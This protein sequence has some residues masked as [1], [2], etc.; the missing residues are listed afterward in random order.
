M[1]E[2]IFTRPLELH[3]DNKPITFNT[4]DEFEFTINSRTAIPLEKIHAAI[5]ASPNEL[6]LELNSIT[7]AIE[8]IT[9]LI[10]DSNE[11]GEVTQQLKE[12]NPV[13]FSN[14]NNWR[15]IFFSLKKDQSAESSHYKKIAL[16]GYLTYLTNRQNMLQALK[17]RF[18]S[19]SSQ[20]QNEEAL[21]FR[22]GE[23]EVADKLDCKS[24]GQQLGMTRITKDE[25]VQISIEKNDK[26]SLLL[27]NYKCKLIVKDAITF[28]D[29][30]NEKYTLSAGENKIGR[31]SDCDI[32]FVD[33]MQR[34]SR[35]HLTIKLIDDKT[36]ELTDHSSY[37]S[38]Y[39]KSKAW[40]AKRSS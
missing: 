29:N 39:S 12:I 14:D 33:T 2:K 16:D 40:R 32:R 38:H 1:L 15:D 4:V 28:V 8:K 22:T 7:V 5:C 6:D 3:I 10:N 23:L 9:E 36:L 37:G 34:I 26:I 24:L 21:S 30:N 20:Q 11:S 31:G 25:P 13:I 19:A 17:I 27:A 18:A 35:L